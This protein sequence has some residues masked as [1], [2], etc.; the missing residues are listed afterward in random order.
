[1]DILNIRSFDIKRKDSLV[2]LSAKDEKEDLKTITFLPLGYHI[3]F[4]NFEAIYSNNGNIAFSKNGIYVRYY[5]WALPFELAFKMK[6]KELFG[7]NE[8]DPQEDNK[9]LT[10]ASVHELNLIMAKI[11]ESAIKM[12]ENKNV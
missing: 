9:F 6:N 3:T 5:K 10:A 2:I 7:K 12:L 11:K 8:K 4:N 1:M